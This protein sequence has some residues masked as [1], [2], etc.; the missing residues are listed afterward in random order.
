MPKKT[1]RGD[2]RDIPEH[3]CACSYCGNEFSRGPIALVPFDIALAHE[4]RWKYLNRKLKNE[5]NPEFL[6]CAINKLTN[7]FYYIC[8]ECIYK[9]FPYFGADYFSY[10][11]ID[12]APSYKSLIKISLIFKLHSFLQ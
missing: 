2:V 9:R 11:G 12:L 4:E 8:K 7:R 3:K 10:S 1:I 5:N 6:P